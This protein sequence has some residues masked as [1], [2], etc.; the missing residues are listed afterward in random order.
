MK[1]TD[2]KNFM[3]NKHW[4]IV[5]IILIS[6]YGIYSGI[7]DLKKNDAETENWTKESK[8]ILIDKC[9]KDSKEMAE[10]YPELTKEY[11]ECSTEK[12]QAK[13][14]QKEYIT[15]S[16]KTLDRQMELLLPEFKNCLADYQNKIK[17]TA[18]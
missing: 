10:K 11:C 15:I 1:K 12:I 8:Q 13:F 18:E 16:E 6:G 7:N 3:T 9:I 14:T 4:L 2:N 17:E 5:L